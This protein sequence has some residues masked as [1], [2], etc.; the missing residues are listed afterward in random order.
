MQGV[1]VE[2]LAARSPEQEPV[3]ERDGNVPVGPG[4]PHHVPALVLVD[5]P[6]LVLRGGRAREAA[7]ERR[8]GRNYARYSFAILHLQAPRRNRPMQ[9]VPPPK[10]MAPRVPAFP[11]RWN[12]LTWSCRVLDRPHLHPS[13][14]EG[15]CS[16]SA[17]R[18]RCR[19]SAD[20]R[21]RRWPRRSVSANHCGDRLRDPPSSAG[22][23]RRTPIAPRIFEIAPGPHGPPCVRHR[24]I[25]AP[26]RAL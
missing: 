23:V 17:R 7:Q 15:R 22:S 4:F 16:A 1:E 12:W 2:V 24:T 25:S 26:Q 6:V 14:V 18:N 11:G 19:R 3:Q 5:R 10:L 8:P 13:T 20:F 9:F 21:L